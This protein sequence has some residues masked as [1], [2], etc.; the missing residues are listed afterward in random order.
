MTQNFCCRLAGTLCVLTFP[1]CV[2]GQGLSLGLSFS[3]TTV[4]V[5]EPSVFTMSVSNQSSTPQVAD[6]TSFFPTSLMAVNLVG[7]NCPGASVLSN[8]VGSGGTLAPGASCYVSAN[9]RSAVPG[10]FVQTAVNFSGVV[11]ATL[12]V[13]TGAPAATYQVSVPG[14]A[15]AGA[16]VTGTLYAMD[17]YGNNVP[18]YNSTAQITSTDPNAVCSG[19]QIT[20]GQ[21]SFTCTFKTAGSQTVQAKDSTGFIGYTT[22][23]VVAGAA[24]SLQP[25]IAPM[26]VSGSPAT[27]SISAFDLY[28]NSATAYIGTIQVTS[29]DPATVCSGG[30]VTGG[31]GSFTCTFKTLGSQTVQI[32]DLAGVLK[33]ASATVNVI[34]QSLLTATPV[35]VA[36]D[37]FTL[38]TLR[39][40]QLTSTS[41]GVSFSASSDSPWLQLTTSG[42]STPATLRITGVDAG[43][44]AGAYQGSVQVTAAAAANG[45]IS[46]PVLFTVGSG[47]PGG[48]DVTSAASLTLGATTP[49]DILTLFAPTLSCGQAPLVAVN[50]NSA[51]ILYAGS[52]QINFVVPASLS[53]TNAQIQA[54]CAGVPLASVTTVLNQVAPALFTQTQT[55]GGQASITNSDGTVNAIGNPASRGAFVS[56]FGTGFGVFNPPGTDGLRRVAA[57]VTAVVGGVPAAVLYAGEAPGETS[58]LQQINVEIPDN[59]P[60]GS[61]V[62]ITLTA[63]GIATQNGTTV[64]LQ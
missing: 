26:V 23:N 30:P 15:T 7:S 59:A 19:A 58:G 51:A 37:D 50:G 22:T 48:T 36:L 41:P 21:G 40:V 57:A 2:A 55:G 29:S 43:L 56:V 11:T 39:N 4:Y 52:T 60:V 18:T 64:A 5:G 38:S 10:T 63:N 25:T 47:V 20:N 6:S 8:V 44:S 33:G 42:S 45:P 28:G 1:F 54:T 14:Q 16:T 46:I 35:T 32:Q 24:A 9:V 34:A 13:I 12:H 31:K 62:P 61:A 27:G 49:N 3:P 17:A 53:G